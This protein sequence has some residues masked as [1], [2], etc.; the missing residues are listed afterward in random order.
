[1]LRALVVGH[2]AVCCVL[3]PSPYPR[4]G[5]PL[6]PPVRLYAFYGLDDFVSVLRAVGAGVV[7]VLGVR[8]ATPPCL[9]PLNCYP[10]PALRPPLLLGPTAAFT[11]V[12][13]FVVNVNFVPYDHWEGVLPLGGSA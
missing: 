11:L 8:S 7:A 5:A 9:F 13:L 6:L 2:C 12:L 4:Y 10:R 3:R 1:M